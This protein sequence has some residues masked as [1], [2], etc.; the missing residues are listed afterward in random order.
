[1]KTIAP[2]I[3]LFMACAVLSS[4][5]SLST[6]T[7]VDVLII[8]GGASGTAAGVQAARLGCHAL[9]IEESPW[10]GGMLT[11]AGVSAI[12]GN[13]RQPSGAWGEFRDSL[14]LRYGGLEALK[15]GWVSNVLFEP[16]VGNAIFQNM[17]AKEPLLQ[18]WQQS[19]YTSV[20][21][22][23]DSW[24]VGISTKG[25]I[26]YVEAKILIDATELGDIAKICGVSYDIGMESRY[27]TGESIA[28][29]AANHIVQDLTYVLILKDYGLPVSV[30]RPKN[31]DPSLFACC[32]IN[33]LCITPKEPNRMWAKDMMLS[34]GQLPNNK[35]MIN[36]PIEGNDYYLNLIELS[37]EDR[38]K[39]LQEAKE[40]S[41]AFLY[42][43]HTELGLTTLGLA[44]DEFPTDDKLPFIPYHRESRRIH[45]KVRFTLDYITSPYT[46][47]HK[48]Y[49]THIAVGDYPVDHHHVRYTGTEVLPDLHFHPVPSYGLPLGTLIPQD[50]KG[51]IV[52]EKSI[53]VSNLVNG[54]TR[55]Q[56]VV[57]QIGQAAGALAALAVQENKDLDEVSVREV[58]KALLAHGAYLMP[59]LD[60]PKEHPLF[61]PLQ[62][63]GA[64]GILQ[65][66]GRNEGWANQ[67]WLRAD[68][69]LLATDLDGLKECYPKL[70]LSGLSAKLS[71]GEALALIQKIAEMEALELPKNLREAAETL[72]ARYQLTLPGDKSP[73]TRGIFAVLVDAWLH[74]FDK[75][76]NIYGNFI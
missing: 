42:F 60:V 69:P 24:T 63:I 10:L 34:Y 1:M 46:Q 50:V 65:G 72:C 30:D 62:R 12:D 52:A 32:C 27:D 22:N 14:S 21:K 29:E 16:S 59:F 41:L 15:T 47:K 7:Q 26:Q 28:P 25:K 23:G 37:R 43:L 35:Y 5:G 67:T 4:C 73:L 38:Q 17:T 58:Q 75:E 18:V 40:H 6:V 70:S 31:Y 44:D 19:H 20:Q 66:E 8:G 51:L 56:P 76:V 13:Y 74:P 49:R 33:D 54:T 71:T 39:A 36:W 48:L 11:A 3:S 2:I 64:S 9:I 68:D 45:G 55:L 57:L 61:Q 53:S